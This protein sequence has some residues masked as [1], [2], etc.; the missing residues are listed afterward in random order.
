MTEPFWLFIFLTAAWYSIWIIQFLNWG[1]LIQSGL[2]GH[3][4]LLAYVKY[5][6]VAKCLLPASFV[7]W[8]CVYVILFYLHCNQYVGTLPLLYVTQ[9]RL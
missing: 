4:N 9:L 1:Y 3:S 5:N 2:H 7:L 8:S 6:L